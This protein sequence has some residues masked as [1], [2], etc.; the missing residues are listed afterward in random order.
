MGILA[1]YYEYIPFSLRAALLLLLLPLSVSV[2]Q[3]FERKMPA[4]HFIQN[5]KHFFHAFIPPP[6]PPPRVNNNNGNVQTNERAREKK[7]EIFSSSVCRRRKK[8][9]WSFGHFVPFGCLTVLPI[10]GSTQKEKKTK[11][12]CFHFSLYAG[13]GDIPLN[14]S[15]MI[16]SKLFFG[17]SPASIPA[18]PSLCSNCNAQEIDERS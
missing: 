17:L 9:Y 6:P 12:K 3:E 18:F 1:F 10:N 5:H 16:R 8:I 15:V 2:S 14:T 11:I 4:S 13:A 7:T